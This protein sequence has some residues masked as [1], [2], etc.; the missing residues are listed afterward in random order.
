MVYSQAIQMPFDGRVP[1][2]VA[3]EDAQPNFTDTEPPAD[4]DSKGP[5]ALLTVYY[6]DIGGKPGFRIAVHVPGESSKVYESL[7]VRWWA[8]GVA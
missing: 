3:V 2:T 6:V 8:L 1:V 7:T 5:M 4:Q